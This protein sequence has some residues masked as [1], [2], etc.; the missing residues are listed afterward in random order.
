MGIDDLVPDLV[1]GRLPI[2]VEVLDEL[3]FQHCVADGVPLL[4]VVTGTPRRAVLV[5]VCK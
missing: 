5:Q 2:D 4:R 3:L 1:N